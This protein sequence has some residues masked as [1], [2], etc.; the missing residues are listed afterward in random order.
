MSDQTRATFHVAVVGSRPA[1]DSKPEQLRAADRLIAWLDRVTAR[2]RESHQLCLVTLTHGIGAPWMA[3]T[4]V[5]DRS[6][7]APPTTRMPKSMP[8]PLMPP[9]VTGPVTVK[10]DMKTNVAAGAI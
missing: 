9:P 6:R 10:P 7:F 5:A 8:I 3:V 2:Y 1:S 4:V